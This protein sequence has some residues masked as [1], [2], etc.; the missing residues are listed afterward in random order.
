MTERDL[1]AATALL[2]DWLPEP[3]AA[4][5]VLGSGLGSFVEGLDERRELRF[6]DVPGLPS[7]GV[8]GHAG[9]FVAGRMEGRA[10]LAQVGRFHRY[11]GHGPG[12][13]GAGVRLAAGVGARFAVLTNAAGALR[14]DYP[15]G[16][17]ALLEDCLDFQGGAHGAAELDPELRR[18]AR[19]SARDLG[20]RLPSAV[21]AGVLGPGYETPAEVSMLRWLGA[22]LVGMSTVG[23]VAA[24][25]RV[26]LPVVA[27]SV[28]TNPAAGVGRGRPGGD[29]LSH[30]EVLA[31]GK[32]AVPGLIRL[33][34]GVV[35]RLA[36]SR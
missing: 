1:K 25:R 28:V 18:I 26:G 29:R 14:A 23:E 15:P 8:K 21:Y 3:P 35:T 9:R 24:A 17:V 5:V 32:R 22:A 6:G 31:A 19:E 30:E 7:A 2:H 12:A 36:E 4:F 27:F 16:T 20:I 11:E 34:R 33:V 10:V 13:V